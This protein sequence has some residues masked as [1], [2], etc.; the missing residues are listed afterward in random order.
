[1]ERE[2]RCPGSFIKVGQK[3]ANDEIREVE[4]GKHLTD[5]IVCTPTLQTE[6]RSV[7]DQLNWLL[8]RTHV[9]RHNRQPPQLGT[10][11]PLHK[12]VRM[13]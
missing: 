13:I 7:L 11:E 9:V 5:H 2:T 4:F 8:S 12:L 6:Y 3:L 10:T 1:M